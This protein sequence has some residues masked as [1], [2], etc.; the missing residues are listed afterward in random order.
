MFELMY[1]S[2]IKDRYF[3]QAAVS[4][5]EDLKIIDNRVQKVVYRERSAEVNK[6]A[7]NSIAVSIFDKYK[8]EVFYR[9]MEGHCMI[10]LKPI[11]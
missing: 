6:E 5:D 3:P 4:G 7:E 8:V 1:Q 10:S 9:M 2:E 11:R